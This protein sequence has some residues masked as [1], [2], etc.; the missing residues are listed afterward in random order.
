MKIYVTR[1]IPD[2]LL[3]PLQDKG[4]EV[5]M[6]NEEEIVVPREELLK[7]VSEADG[8]LCMLTDTIDK[9]ILEAGKN[10]KVI[11]NIAVGFNNID[12]EEARKRGIIVTNTPDVLTEATADTTF[13]L[14]LSAARN[15]TESTQ[16]LRQGNWGPW[17]LLQMTG[18]DLNKSTLGIIGLGRIGEAVVRR[19][20]GFGMNILYYNRSRK[21][22][23]EKE[24]NINY[25]SFENVLKKSDF[26]CLLVPYSP[27]L[28]H[29]IGSRELKMMKETAV[30]INTA[31]GGLVDE[32][33]LYNALKNK[34]IYAAGL[35]VFERE[36]VSKD[37]PLLNLSNFEA[38]PHIGSATVNTRMTMG[39][40]AVK[41]VLNVL[42]GEKPATPV[43]K[44]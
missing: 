24:L 5:T 36:P 25:D 28:H 16:I 22:H 19:A 41:N 15:Y 1:K 8:L 17:S 43:W 12:V 23:I 11:G 29:M 13:L 30:L 18:Q 14:L 35:D 32:E 4:F 37:H 40:L 44:D 6:W 38:L 33:A 34:E 21:E 2:E 9:E 39:K 3:I 7:N 10:L 42:V 27:Q 31:R 26:V 20:Q